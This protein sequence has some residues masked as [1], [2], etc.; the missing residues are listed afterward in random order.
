L[1]PLSYPLSGAKPRKSL[2]RHERSRPDFPGPRHA[3]ACAS[4]ST[5]TVGRATKIPRP[6]WS[7]KLPRALTIPGIA[8]INTLADVREL[9]DT[10]RMITGPAEPAACRTRAK[11]CCCRR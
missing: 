11:S 10:C 5:S 1:C 2:L 9:M 6:D 7:R 4:R 3:Q 8:T